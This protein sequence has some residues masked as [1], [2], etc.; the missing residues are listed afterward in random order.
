ML[1]ES[2]LRNQKAEI[3]AKI[4]E[5]AQYLAARVEE[6]GES[7][8]DIR[9][10]CDRSLQLVKEA[11]FDMEVKQESMDL[12]M[13]NILKMNSREKADMQTAN[14]K[15]GKRIQANDKQVEDM[16]QSIYSLATISLCLIECSCMQ[17]RAEEQDDEDKKG[18]SLMG[19]K[20]APEGSST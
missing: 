7:I 8:F 11:K 20:E 17:I 5:E 18:I 3:E 19:Q 4:A 1:V 15:I 10:D 16:L 14:E 12:E 13:R 9:K 2:Q 6:Q